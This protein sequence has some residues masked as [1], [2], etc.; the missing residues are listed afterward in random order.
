MVG[1]CGKGL[2]AQQ[3]QNAEYIRVGSGIIFI[4][5]KERESRVGEREKVLAISCSLK[6]SILVHFDLRI[7]EI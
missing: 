6:S 4:I 3:T 7:S 5:R 1:F 2:L